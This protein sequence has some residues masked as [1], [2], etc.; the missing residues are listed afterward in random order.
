MGWFCEV[1][2]I[3]LK[4]CTTKT[5]TR[6]NGSVKHTKNLVK[7]TKDVSNTNETF[8]ITCEKII[9]DINHI[10]FP[11]QL[12]KRVVETRFTDQLHKNLNHI[13]KTNNLKIKKYSGDIDDRVDFV[14]VNG[15]TMSVKTNLNSDK[16]CPQMIG[17]TTR[18]KFCSYFNIPSDSPE[19]IKK[20]I[21]NNHQKLLS[22]YFEHTFCCDY[23][24]WINEKTAECKLITRPNV[25]YFPNVSFTRSLNNWN[26]SNTLK[27]QLTEKSKPMTLGEFQF[28]RNRNCIKFRFN[29]LNLI[30]LISD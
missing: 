2:K 11:D 22:N 27:I 24:L 28:H 8:G 5:I 16:I 4:H 20:W 19:I 6:H 3:T 9:C 23:L 17:Q 13:L 15:Q 26:E 21:L 14:L 29:L 12:K 10:L 25:V 1:C 30:K 18:K 7:N